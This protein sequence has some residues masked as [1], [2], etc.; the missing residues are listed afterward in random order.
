MDLKNFYDHLDEFAYKHWFEGIQTPWQPLDTLQKSVG[1]AI[2]QLVDV[3]EVQSL[4]GLRFAE[5]GPLPR[6]K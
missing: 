3:R 1:D 2:D 4:D 6:L 5:N